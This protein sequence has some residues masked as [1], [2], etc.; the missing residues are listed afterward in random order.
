MAEKQVR[1][2]RS[3]PSDH[4]WSRGIPSTCNDR[5]LSAGRLEGRSTSNEN[6]ALR[7]QIDR[8]S[9]FEDIAGSSEALAKLCIEKTNET[10][11]MS[12]ANHRELSHVQYHRNRSC[13][14][15]HGFDIVRTIHL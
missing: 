2:S 11:S 3:G 7:E 4:D 13:D 5:R 14:A 1:I 15:V 10:H 6:L 8:E 9:M 12:S